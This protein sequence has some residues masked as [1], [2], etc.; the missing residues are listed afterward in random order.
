MKSL[1]AKTDTG[2]T[3]YSKIIGTRKFSLLYQIFCYF[4]SQ[5]NKASYFIGTGE[6]LVSGILLYQI[7]VYRVST[8]HQIINIYQFEILAIKATET[9]RNKKT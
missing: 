6:K 8:V 4:S 1:N 3:Q 7:L 5:Q 2:E 9:Q